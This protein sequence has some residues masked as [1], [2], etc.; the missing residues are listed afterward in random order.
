MT[1]GP[2]ADERLALSYSPLL[3]GV[4]FLAM[5]QKIHHYCWG[6]GKK[7]ERKKNSF[8]G[9]QWS[10]VKEDLTEEN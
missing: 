3:D 8:S 1:I 4:I 6:E 2:S 7:K 10:Q 5:N 9:F